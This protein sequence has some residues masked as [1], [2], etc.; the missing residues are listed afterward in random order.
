M[1]LFEV[2]GLVWIMDIVVLLLNMEMPTQKGLF[3]L[4]GTF[5][6]TELCK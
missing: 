1:L 4:F 3:D 5:Q 6:H 2:R